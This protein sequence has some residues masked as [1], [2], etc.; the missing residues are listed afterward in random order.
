VL[1]VS[2]ERKLK[3]RAIR[4][5]AEGRMA[6]DLEKLKRSVEGGKL[7]DPEKIHERIGRIKERYP[8]VA[9]YFAIHY[10]P[11][12]GLLSFGSNA[13]LR[14]VAD[15]SYLLKTDRCDLSPEEAWNLYMLLARVERAFGDLKGPLSVRPIFHHLAHRTEAHIFLHVLAYHLLVAIE[16][17]LADRGVHTSWETVRDK[18][19]THQVVTVVLPTTQGSIL[20]IRR[21]TTPEPDHREIYEI[22][23]IPE[24][25]DTS[26]SGPG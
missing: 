10:D 6:S 26:P 7:K 25:P 24:E 2:A 9:R 11:G 13:S 12:K 17:S 23:G 5:L 19:K 18:L 4:E 3:D 15:Y 22:L 20:K 14:R 8:R 1:V 16:K 21:A